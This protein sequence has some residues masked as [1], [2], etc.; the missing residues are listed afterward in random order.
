MLGDDNLVKDFSFVVAQC[1]RYLAGV[2]KDDLAICLL[3]CYEQFLKATTEGPIAPRVQGA[4]NDVYDA[5][6][7]G[8]LKSVARQVFDK[9]FAG[10]TDEQL[11]KLVLQNVV[12]ALH[13]HTMRLCAG[14]MHY[15]IAPMKD[16]F[17][18]CRTD[19]AMPSE[20]LKFFEQ[21]DNIFK[22]TKKVAN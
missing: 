10:A 3:D 20:C 21:L 5:I 7:T 8:E 16:F 15:S 12:Y 17:D 4:V 18:M 11:E 2:D 6:G 1:V 22:A 13:K 19:A 14:K 9:M